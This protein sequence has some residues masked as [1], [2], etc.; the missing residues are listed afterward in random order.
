MS[1]YLLHKATLLILHDLC[2]S[3]VPELEDVLQVEDGDC[4]TG[5]CNLLHLLHERISC[6]GCV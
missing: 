2:H 1:K 6:D 4:E 5:L 3:T